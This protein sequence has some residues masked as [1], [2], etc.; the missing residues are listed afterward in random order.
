MTLTQLFDLSLVGRRDRIALEFEGQAFTFG[1]VDERSNR[2]A[3]FLVAHGLGAGDRLCVQLA[4]CVEMI[5]LYLACVKLGVIFV[6]INILYRERE[7]DHILKD[8]EPKLFLQEPPNAD[9]FP[10]DRP[11]VTLD[12][13]TPAG[14]IYTSGT[15]GASKG[16][17]LTHDNFA[18]NAVNLLTCWQIGA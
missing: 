1:E 10:S 7:I 16:A 12:G 11:A 9:S 17:V 4:N 14:I 18:A 15:T 3:H 13:S 8:A 5:D 2:M 6:P